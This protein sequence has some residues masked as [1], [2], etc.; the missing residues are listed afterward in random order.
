MK[1]TILF[2][3]SLVLAANAIAQRHAFRT[4]TSGPVAA[5]KTT[6]VGDTLA[7]TNINTADT[8]TMYS[9]PAGGFVTGPNSFGD[10]GFAER[11]EINGHDSSVTVIG[12]MSHF[13]GKVNPAS[14]HSVNFKVWGLT[15]LVPITSSWAYNSF[16]GAGLD[17]ITVPV[18]H[19]GIGTTVDT[20]KSFFFPHPTDTIQGAFFVGYDMTYN[21][22]SLNGDTLGLYSTQNGVRNSPF[23]NIVMSTTLTEEPDTTYDTVIVVQNATLWSDNNWRE[24]YT[25]NDSIFNNL[26]IYPIVVI[27]QPTGIGSVTRNGLTFFGN[28]PNPA[29]ETTNIRFSLANPADVTIS[30]MDMNGR[31]VK[32]IKQLHLSASEHNIPLNVSSLAPGV[33]VYSIVTSS[34]DGIAGRL[35]VSR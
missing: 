1:K 35:T 16:P 22:S 3:L 9:Y 18:T 19:L 32:N 5:A 28:Y 33:Y 6:A 24:N 12:V 21:Y 17:T 25:Q 20:V 14:T 2:V 7:L 4:H 26:A 10:R 8:L 11:Y 29:S 27:G 31:E 13:G 15:P 34:G 23:Y 30:V